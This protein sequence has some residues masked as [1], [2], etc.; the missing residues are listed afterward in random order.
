VANTAEPLKGNREK[1][2]VQ[3]TDHN[4]VIQCPAF[5]IKNQEM[6]DYFPKVA[7]GNLA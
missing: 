2:Y 4:F 1:I 7:V 5:R 3:K 6:D